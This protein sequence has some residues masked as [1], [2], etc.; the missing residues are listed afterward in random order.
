MS[1]TVNRLFLIVDSLVNITR[2]KRIALWCQAVS[3]TE[4]LADMPGEKRT[5][6][7]SGMNNTPP[8]HTTYSFTIVL[9]CECLQARVCIRQVTITDRVIDNQEQQSEHNEHLHYRYS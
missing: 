1:L 9:L 4:G 3:V 7:L 8:D 6:G 2:C 5:P